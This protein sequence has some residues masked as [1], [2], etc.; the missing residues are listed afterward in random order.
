MDEHIYKLNKYCEAITNKKQQRNE[1]IT[2][3]RSACLNLKMGTQ[4][5]RNS[6]DLVTQKLE[7]RPKTVLLNKRVRTSVAEARVCR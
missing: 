2:P 4:I 3:E 7:D 1:V 6:P 5:N